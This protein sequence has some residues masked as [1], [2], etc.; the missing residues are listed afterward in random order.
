MSRLGL[1]VQLAAQDARWPQLLAAA[2]RADAL[3]YDHIWLP[4]HLLPI[5]GRESAPIFEAYTALGAIAAST[6]RAGLGLLVGA[7]TFRN[8]AVL[9]KTVLTLDHISGGRAI[10]GIGAGWYLREHEAYGI[11]V[12]SSAGDRLGRLDEALGLIRPLLHGE[13]VTRTG[14][15]YRTDHLRLSPGPVGRPVPILVG[16][17]GER[18]TL[19]TVARYADLWNAQVSLADAPHKLAVLDRHCAEVGRDPADIERTLDCAVIIRDTEAAARGALE[20]GF[21]AAGLPAP[22]PDS[23][24][25]WS[26]TP[27]QIAARMRAFVDL[28]FTTITC[29]FQPPYDEES[30]TRLVDEVRP[31]VLGGP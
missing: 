5:H 24:F 18:R 26:G 20:A 3:G 12:G 11:D 9:A 17:V 30:L 19:R 2:T 4:D 27:G 1:G 22:P 8:P 25:H 10:L 16:G 28:G 29:E 23:S 14:P 6:S 15:T 7:N 31:L 13:E 21:D